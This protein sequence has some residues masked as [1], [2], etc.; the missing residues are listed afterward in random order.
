MD[1]K[2]LSILFVATISL[3]PGCLGLSFGGKTTYVQPDDQET[4][5]R[6]DEL[7]QRLKALEQERPSSVVEIPSENSMN[8]GPGLPYDP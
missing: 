2:Y 7:E 3:I 5:V 8:T 6:L 4:I 1:R